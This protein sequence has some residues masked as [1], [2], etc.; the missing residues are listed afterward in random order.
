VCLTALRYALYLANHATL[1][2]YK[3][4][5]TK[6]AVN[7]SELRF[8]LHKQKGEKTVVIHAAKKPR[9]HG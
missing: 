7:L 1:S 9:H 6:T 2:G 5:L 4:S 8:D 3:S